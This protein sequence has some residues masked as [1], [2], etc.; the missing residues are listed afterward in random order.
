MEYS[1]PRATLRH[2]LTELVAAH[3]RSGLFVSFPVEI[4]WVKGDD[5]PLSTASG[6]DSAYI[7]VHIAKGTPY[8]PWF[9]VAEAIF[10]EVGGRPHWG[11]MHYQRAESLAPRYPQWDRFWK[12]R[13]TLDPEDRFGNAETRRV[14][15]P[16]G[17]ICD[18][19]AAEDLA[20]RRQISTRYPLY[21]TG[22][23]R[24]GL[25]DSRLTDD[26][27]PLWRRGRAGMAGRLHRVRCAH[28]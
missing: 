24:R 9:R 5:I 7:A 13:R 14:L 28:R 6:R 21:T 10:D 17:S 3:E 16:I 18:D 27:E 25:P 20:R 12:V 4:R 26:L 11:K 15:G 8:E 23:C 1:V 19:F 22:E 2:C